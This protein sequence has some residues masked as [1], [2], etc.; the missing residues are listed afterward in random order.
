M[1]MSIKFTQLHSK[2]PK[3]CEHTHTYIYSE[4]QTETEIVIR[5]IS[6][7]LDFLLKLRI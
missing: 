1:K 4:L 3:E 6:S 7:Y 5:T 2:H